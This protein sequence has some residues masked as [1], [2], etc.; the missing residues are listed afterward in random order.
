M[1]LSLDCNFNIQWYKIAEEIA[2]YLVYL[3]SVISLSLFL[4]DMG[5]LPKVITPLHVF[6]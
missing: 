1:T 2:G 5:F 3:C 6:T 4:K